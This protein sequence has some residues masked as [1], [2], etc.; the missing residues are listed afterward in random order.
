MVST[1]AGREDNKL[2]AFANDNK[3]GGFTQRNITQMVF[4]DD[5]KQAVTADCLSPHLTSNEELK[6]QCTP[7]SLIC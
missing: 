1:G 6:D 3:I 2:A 4:T 7:N 5:H